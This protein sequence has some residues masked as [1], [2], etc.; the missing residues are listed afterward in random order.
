[1]PWP[2]VLLS[3]T[4]LPAA[5][6]HRPLA[7]TCVLTAAAL[8]TAEA[9]RGKRRRVAV[10]GWVLTT[11]A[12]L[13]TGWSV[14]E[15][16][17]PIPDAPDSVVDALPYQ[18]SASGSRDVFLPLTVRLEPVTRLALLDLEPDADPLY[19]GLEPQYLDRG[20][21]AGYRVIAYRHDGYVDFYDDLALTASPDVDSQVTGNGLANYRHT[22]IDGA[23]IERDELGRARISAAFTDVIGRRIEIDLEEFSPRATVPFDLLAPVGMGSARP[24]YFPLF[25][26]NDFDFLRTAGRH[27]VRIDEVSHPPAG[28]PAP[29]PLVVQGSTRTWSK[30]TL[31]A[32][33]ISVFPTTTPP[34]TVTTVLGTDTVV[35]GETTYLFARE[36]T[37]DALERIRVRDHEIVF[38]PPLSLRGDSDR[39]GRTT[40]R[41]SITSYPARGVIAGPYTVDT[42]GTSATL[43]IDIDEVEAPHQPDLALRGMVRALGFFSAW[44]RDYSYRATF[45]LEAGTLDGRWSNARTVAP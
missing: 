27:E 16:Y 29:V 34:R 13:V 7:A 45:D 15:L 21:E 39:G 33:I 5:V 19:S 40:G 24:D 44:P 22:R 43:R 11:V 10:A 38:S 8:L 1:M 28:F 30:Y 41:M 2:A 37:D 42:D 35:E 18:R 25:M 3:L 32:E 6:I 20:T 31:D 26:C 17:R 9:A 4:A 12:A 23:R 14:A 36:G